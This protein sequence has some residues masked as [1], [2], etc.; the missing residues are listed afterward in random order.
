MYVF[1]QGIIR[2]GFIVVCSITFVLDVKRVEFAKAFLLGVLYV[3]L[4]LAKL[5]LQ[6]LVREI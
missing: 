1:A 5:F 2:C 6:Y 3:A 4:F